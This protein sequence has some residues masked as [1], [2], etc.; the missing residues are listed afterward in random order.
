M[1]QTATETRSVAHQQHTPFGPEAFELGRLSSSHA[2]S[3]GDISPKRD[4]LEEHQASDVPDD[5]PPPHA[6]GALE[7]WNSPKGNV[8]RL[9]FAFFSFIIAGMNDAAVG[10]LIPY[11]ETYYDLSYTVVSLIF[12]TPFAGYSVAA[13]TNARIHQKF[14]Q[15]GVA[16]MAPLC[17]I[18]TYVVLALHPPYPVL[19]VANAISGFGNGLTDACF[20][21][22]IGAMDQANTI[23]GF[24]HSSYSV[25]AL[26]SPL[27]A[28]SMVVTAQLP[29]YNYYYVMVGA[30]VL[31]LVGLVITFW[32][33]TGAVYRAEHAH[34]NE[35]QGG[36]GTRV[37]LKSKVTWLCSLFFFAYMGVEVGLGGWIVTFMLRVR[38]AS[39]YAS[40]VSATGFWAGQALGRACLG[41]VTERFG[42]RL[43][44]SI[45]LVICI[46]LQLLFWLVPQ[47]VVSAI[48]VAFLGFFLGPL[49][50][51]AVMMTAKLL[52]KHIHV[53]AI[54]FAMAIGGTGGT[55]FP[56]IIGAIATSR[57]VSVL[58]PIVLSLIAVVIIVWLCFPRI[59]KKD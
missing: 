29:W 57:G 18:I 27:I 31:E 12:L 1:S 45:Y 44:I 51:G 40:G 14:G 25:G 15:R 34:E 53:S 39:A 46:A 47:F 24:L 3:L 23:Q 9:G 38:K 37:A 26:I 41:F 33:K 35:G 11:L 55:V 56:F 48:A 54:G 28:T 42:E 13:F 43:C 22:W 8:G 30:A 5:S 49:F 6:H 16:I 2:R 21:A 32:P 4:G 59:Q 19:V 17:H 58:Q 52:P 7:R 36:A 10:A 50:P 20:C